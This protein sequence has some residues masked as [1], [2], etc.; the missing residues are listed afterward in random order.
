MTEP[1]FNPRRRALN[2]SALAL[3]AAEESLRG[4]QDHF[5]SWVIRPRHL[6]PSLSPQPT[7]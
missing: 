2:R 1:I 6:A 3:E 4:G 5:T 7:V